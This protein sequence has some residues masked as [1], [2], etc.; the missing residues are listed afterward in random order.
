MKLSP[1]MAELLKLIA[2]GGCYECRRFKPFRPSGK[3][4]GHKQSTVAALMA[5]GLVA[6][7]THPPGDL[8][9]PFLSYVITGNGR[10]LLAK[11]EA[12]WATP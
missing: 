4:G 10:A 9:I 7:A 6:Y 12:K 3:A 5:R 2:D 1:K 11:L 8:Y